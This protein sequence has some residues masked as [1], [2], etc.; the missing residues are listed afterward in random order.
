MKKAG[1]TM[2]RAYEVKFGAETEF[3]I[4]PGEEPLLFELLRTKVAEEWAPEG[5]VEE[6]LVHTVAKCIWR[7]QRIQRFIAAKFI[8]AKFDP[9]SKAYDAVLALSAFRQLFEI[10]TEEH[11]IDRILR[12]LG[13]HF[14]QHLRTSCPET[15]FDSAAEWV[16]ALKVEIDTVLMPATTR[17]G[18][19]PPPEGLLACSAAVLDDELFERELE[20]EA[21]IDA[22][23]QR[24]LDRL[25][26]IKAAKRR[27]TFGERRRFAEIH[28]RR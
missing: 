13:G 9:E 6:D 18:G 4:V 10:Q 28:H 11:E 26:K 20:L 3:A 24:A 16:D 14:E 8:A 17:L 25:E 21:R 7:K 15:E 5:P 12:A 27:I 19:P 1:K 2:R 22:T 23:L